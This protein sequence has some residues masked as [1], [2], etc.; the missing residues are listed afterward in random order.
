MEIQ[1]KY[2]FFWL[3]YVLFQRKFHQILVREEYQWFCLRVH[4]KFIPQQNNYIKENIKIQQQQN[5]QKSKKRRK[6]KKEKENYLVNL[7]IYIEWAI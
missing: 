3:Q 4:V 2:I 6:K 1:C 5:K 7:R